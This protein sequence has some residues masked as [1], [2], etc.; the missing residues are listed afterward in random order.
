MSEVV[1]L[2]ASAGE[3]LSP[4]PH[5]GTQRA[6]GTSLFFV[7]LWKTEPHWKALPLLPERDILNC[8]ETNDYRVSFLPVCFE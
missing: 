7:G 1:A 8:V 3:G 2:G 4:L 5:G 6:L